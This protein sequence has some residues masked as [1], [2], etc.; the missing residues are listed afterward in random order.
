M[1]VPSSA[2]LLACLL[3][4]AF[5]STSP[6]GVVQAI[7]K[8][9]QDREERL[10]GYTVTEHYTIRNSRFAAPAEMT[11]S[12]TY[13]KGAG[14][15]YHV[16]SRSGPSFLQTHV[17][18]RLLSEQEQLSRGEK[19]AKILV[20]SANYQIKLIGKENL[21]GRLCD[22]VE[23]NPRTKSPH[24]LKGK[25]WVDSASQLLLR[26]EGKPTASLSFL[27]GRPSVVRDYAEVD[28]FSLAEKS[29]AVSESFLLGKTDLTIEYTGYRVNGSGTN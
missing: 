16:I 26:I 3:I 14:K 12:I 5:A 18:D 10:N 8:A 25:A 17:L 11:V 7:D 22:V 13:V 19:R 29:H 27:A 23:L 2:S 15:K 28:G 9:Q 1:L 24:L 6:D 4:P 20:T 21:N